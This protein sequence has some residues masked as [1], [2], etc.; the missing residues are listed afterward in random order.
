[1]TDEQKEEILNEIRK[2]HGIAMPEKDPAFAVITALEIVARRYLQEVDILMTKQSANYEDTTVKYLDKAKEL[3]EVKISNAVENVY[4]TL[5]E[6]KIN[7]IK[8]VQEVKPK[9]E[10]P[11]FY[12]IFTLMAGAMGYMLCLSII[13]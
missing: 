13:G 9:Q 10:I 5:D 1:M 7:T 6:F 4:E 8:E 3:A 2:I 12:W 11:L